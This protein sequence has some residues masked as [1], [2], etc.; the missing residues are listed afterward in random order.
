MERVEPRWVVVCRGQR[1]KTT[2]ATRRKWTRQGTSLPRDV[3][4]PSSDLLQLVLN[5]QAQMDSMQT[6]STFSKESD[7]SLMQMF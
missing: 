2:A 1:R 6:S 3:C 4:L 5:L 7:Q